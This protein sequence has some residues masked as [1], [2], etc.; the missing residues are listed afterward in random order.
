MTSCLTLSTKEK[1]LT[2]TSP[3]PPSMEVLLTFPNS[4]APE[5][6]P[7]LPSLLTIFPWSTQ[8]EVTGLRVRFVRSV[9][10]MNLFGFGIQ[11]WGITCS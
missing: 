2:S 10:S 6:T 8:Q 7:K 5:V 3:W 9:M 11:L 1:G 4:R